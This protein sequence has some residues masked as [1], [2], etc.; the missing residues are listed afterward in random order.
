MYLSK[1]QDFPSVLWLE[2]RLRG[3]KSSFLVVSHDRELLNNVCTAVLLIEDAQIKYYNCDFKAFEKKKAADDK[4][5]YEEIEKFL[6]KNQ[7]VDPSTFLGRQKH[8]KK[9]YVH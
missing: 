1:L 4:K 5:K 9:Q 2:N 7:N 8:D 3:Y 6:I